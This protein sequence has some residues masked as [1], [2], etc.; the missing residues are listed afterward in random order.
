MKSGNMAPQTTKDQNLALALY[1]FLE[2]SD[3]ATRLGRVKFEADFKSQVKNSLRRAIKDGTLIFK[4]FNIKLESDDIY[5]VRENFRQ[6]QLA[7]QGNSSAA[8]TTAKFFNSLVSDNEN[9]IREIMSA[10]ELDSEVE[11]E[12]KFLLRCVS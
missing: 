12:L 3:Y 7:L 5:A 1:A 8:L 6:K 10:L 4:S 2:L 11:N 9:S